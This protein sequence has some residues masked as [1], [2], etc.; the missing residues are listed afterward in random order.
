[1]AVPRAV[2]PSVNVAV[3]VAVGGVTV[4][5]K[6]AGDP[7]ADGFVGEFSI[8]VVLAWLTVCVSAGEVLALSFV[9]PP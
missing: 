7:Y 3:P 9:S 8:T 2:L 6:V 4:T 1:M 5:V